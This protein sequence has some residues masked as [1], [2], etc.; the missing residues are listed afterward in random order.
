MVDGIAFK[1]ILFKECKFDFIVRH[2][3]S[4]TRLLGFGL[5]I[6][7]KDPNFNSSYNGSKVLTPLNHN[8]PT[9]I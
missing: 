7:T 9:Y 8:I 6:I 2:L 1:V 5:E 3:K 4:K